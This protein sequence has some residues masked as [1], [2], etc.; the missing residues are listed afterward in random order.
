MHTRTA[1]ISLALLT[2]NALAASSS[3]FM[4]SET[5]LENIQ[6]TIYADYTL[7]DLQALYNPNNDYVVKVPA[8]AATVPP[9][10][11]GEIDFNFCTYIQSPCIANNKTYAKM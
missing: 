10:L 7:F 11:A 6:C 1:L 9:T 4:T 8:N 3:A 2:G 5:D